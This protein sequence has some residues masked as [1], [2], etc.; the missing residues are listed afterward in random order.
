MW[1]LG[2]PLKTTMDHGTTVHITC[3]IHDLVRKARNTVR[4]LD[5]QNELTF[6]RLRS[7][8]HEIMCAPGKYLLSSDIS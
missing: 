4:E 5:S 2:I 3:L 8:K 7:K 1:L 6:L